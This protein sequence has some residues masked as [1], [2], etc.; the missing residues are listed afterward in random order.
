[1]AWPVATGA[2]L[3]PFGDVQVLFSV[4]RI[5]NFPIP[6]GGR[7]E[8]GGEVPSVLQTDC[9]RNAPGAAVG[10]TCPAVRRGSTGA[11][12][13]RARR[14]AP[15]LQSNCAQ[16]F[17]PP[18]KYTRVIHNAGGR[19]SAGHSTAATGHVDTAGYGS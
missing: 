4:A 1:M 16:Y 14:S 5:R 2:T 13:P 11:Q 6:V 7:R 9:S 17:A 8:G 18:S 19:E 12:Q 3:R 10:C 15:A